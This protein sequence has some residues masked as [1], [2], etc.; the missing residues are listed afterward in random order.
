MN[1]IYIQTLKLGFE[2]PEGISFNEVVEQLDI[3]LSDKSFKINY[4]HWFYSNFY[5]DNTERFAVGNK[6]AVNSDYR[7][8]A[9]TITQISHSNHLKSFIKGDAVNKYIDYLE[10]ERTR[11]SSRQASLFATGSL[12]I[13]ILAV[14]L[15]YFI[16]PDNIN[17]SGRIVLVSIL[18]TIAAGIYNA[19]DIAKAAPSKKKRF[20]PFTIIITVLSLALSVLL[21]A[22]LNQLVLN[23]E[24]WLKTLAILPVFVFWLG[25]VNKKLLIFSN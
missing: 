10:L 2:N 15:P 5:N 14:M 16:S 22:I 23:P 25:Q 3:D 17:D 13:A 24:W 8:S 12:I 18:L 20:W 6:T 4:T 19:I 7:I 21:I 1:N 11:E 9:T